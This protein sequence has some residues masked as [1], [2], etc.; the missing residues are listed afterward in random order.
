VTIRLLLADGS[1]LVRTAL[2]Q[3]LEFQADME[4]VGEAAD[5][6]AAIALAHA[7]RPDI[8]LLDM[9]LPGAGG[10]LV[11]ARLRAEAPDVR[12]ILLTTFDCGSVEAGIIAAGAVSCLNKFG[13]SHDVHG[14]IRR[15]L[16]C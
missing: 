2:R 8:V 10:I 5:S 12:V 7:L 16:H 11:T 14:V 3:L 4:V 13:P 6:V 1:A 15:S 9:R